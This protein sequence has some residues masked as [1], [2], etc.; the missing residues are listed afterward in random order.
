MIS[1]DKLLD[2]VFNSSETSTIFFNDFGIPIF[3]QPKP[4]PSPSSWPCGAEP[5]WMMNSSMLRHQRAFRK[6][7]LPTRQY[8][9][10]MMI[11]YD[12][13]L[14]LGYTPVSNTP[15]L[16]WTPYPCAWVWISGS[17]DASAW[18]SS[19]FGGWNAQQNQKQQATVQDLQR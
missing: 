19:Q 4:W 1:Y 10:F 7:I 14:E 5:S 8:F 17:R 6:N 11:I 12:N 9:Q 16:L 2:S 15:A 18:S 13:A 3:F